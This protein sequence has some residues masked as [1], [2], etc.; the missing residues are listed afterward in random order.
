MVTKLFILLVVILGVIALAQIMRV[1]ELSSKI[2]KNNE[3]EI[4]NRDNRINAKLMLTFMIVLFISV[5]WMFTKYGWTGRGLAASEHGHELDWLLNLNLV[6][7]YA[8]QTDN[9]FRFNQLG[10]MIM[11]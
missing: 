10:Y 3:Y 6:I 1:Y 2:T 11:I 9:L 4:S 5:I 8:I 7:Y